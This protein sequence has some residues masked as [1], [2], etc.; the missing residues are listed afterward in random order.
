[1]VE[2]CLSCEE[3]QSRIC[4]L[5]DEISS[6]EECQGVT[7]DE[8]G[9]KVDR[10]EQIKAKYKALD[11]LEKLEARKCPK[12]AGELYEFLAVPC[13]RPATCVGVGCSNRTGRVNRRRYRR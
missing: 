4:T 13:V 7:I 9:I 3:I 10:S 1:M 5:L 2:S 11:T 6:L 8:D 12:G